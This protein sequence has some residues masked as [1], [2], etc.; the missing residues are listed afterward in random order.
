MVIASASN[1]HGNIT[2]IHILVPFD[3]AISD[4]FDLV[5]YQQTWK[6][7]LVEN[8]GCTGDDSGHLLP[9]GT[10]VNGLM[11]VH[12]RAFHFSTK[13]TF[14]MFSELIPCYWRWEAT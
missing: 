2:F 13:L 5:K 11:N 8:Q 14:P 1:F 6:T 4:S 10:Q 7:V 12:S 3:D 9:R